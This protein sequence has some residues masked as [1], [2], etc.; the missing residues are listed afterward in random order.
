[1]RERLRLVVRG[2]VQGVG[3][4]PFVFRLATEIG[5]DGWVLNAP[6][7]VW[8]ELEGAPDALEQFRDRLGAELPP[9]AAIHGVESV[10]LDPVPYADFEI[11]ESRAGGRM[12]ALVP[13]DIAL[14][15]DCR[16]EIA[17]PTD[18]RFRYPFTN[19]TNCGPRFTII[20]ALPYDRASTSMRDF[21]MCPACAAEYHDPANRRFHAQPNACPACGPRLA[22]QDERGRPLS[23]ADDA[24][25]QTAEAI[26]QGRIVAVKGLGGFHLIANAADP[27]AIERLR[28]RKGREEKPFALMC[29]SLETVQALCDS[30]AAETRLLQSP[31]APIVLLAR[32]RDPSIDLAL[33]VAPGCPTLGV[34]LPYTPLHRLLLDDVGGPVIATSG[35]L[36][37]EPICIDNQEAL[38][39]LGGVADLFLVHDRPIVRHVDD[40]IVRVVMGRELVLRRARGYAPWPVPVRGL[41]E[42]VLALGGH[43]KNTV[44]LG[45]RGQVVLSQHLGDLDTPQAV[46]AFTRTVADLKTLLDVAPARVVADAHPGYVS[47]Q[48]ARALTDAPV[49][50]QHHLAHVAAG[51]AEND[52]DPPA[53]GVAWDGTGYGVDGTIWGGEWLLVRDGAWSRAACLRPF[54]LPGGEAAIREPRRAAFGLLHALV[55]ADV[56]DLD[57][58]PVRAFTRI[59]RKVLR[60]AIASGLNA[61][62]TTSAGRLFDAVAALIGLRE[63][64]TFE[65]QTAMA[66]EWAAG[67]DV[68]ERYPFALERGAD[69]VPMGA[70]TPPPLVV[71]W[72]PAVHAI[73]AD[74]GDDLPLGRIAAKFHNTLAAMIVAAAERLGERKVVLTG[75]CF[76][77][78]R[79]TERTVAGLRAAGFTPYWHQRVPPNDGGLA[80]GQI[81]AFAHGLH[82]RTR[83]SAAAAMA[84]TA[85]TGAARAGEE[86]RSCV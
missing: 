66:L 49:L 1:M 61:P 77:N 72:A 60:H 56:V 55:G 47:T 82:E 52:L 23:E 33:A 57:L 21:T 84:G 64:T 48:R 10:W 8:I 16:R 83:A 53:L 6:D 18:R 45:T 63:R 58:P 22:L 12:T 81:A 74:L 25:R 75:G 51:M 31:E 69:A 73:I 19:C 34:M 65:G 62:V 86:A 46:A 80:L 37:D 14:C 2:A 30:S 70:W 17:S 54:R 29:P 43:L 40:S 15:D 5:L 85:A 44:A 42:P 4:R 67:P 24:L 79:L 41:D 71:N 59:E 76:Q 78:R 39:R 68:E 11:R 36:S 7:G 20:H 28:A 13:P 38:A 32:R 35:N 27:E 50:V 3:F 9:R 26:R